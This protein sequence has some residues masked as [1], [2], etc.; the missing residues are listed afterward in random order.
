MTEGDR[1]FWQECE[2][3][4]LRL[5]QIHLDKMAFMLG[6]T[7]DD[8]RQEFRLCYWEIACGQMEF[9]GDRAAKATKAKLMRRNLVNCRTTPKASPCIATRPLCRPSKP[10]RPNPTT[11]RP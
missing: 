11:T 1:K 5:N 6:W 7:M 8:V 4:F 3:A 10:G 2:A 9:C